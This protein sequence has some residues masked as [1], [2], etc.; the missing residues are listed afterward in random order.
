MS[1][2]SHGQAPKGNWKMKRLQQ[3]GWVSQNIDTIGMNWAPQPWL[4]TAEMEHSKVAWTFHIYSYR[5][6]KKHRK[7]RWRTGKGEMT[8]GI[9]QK[10]CQSQGLRADFSKHVT[11]PGPLSYRECQGLEDGVSVPVGTAG[12]TFGTVRAHLTHDLM[13]LGLSQFLL[14]ML[15][16]TEETGR[17]VKCWDGR[18]LNT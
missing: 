16:L 2:R 1:L 3:S 10:P 17:T 15:A 13:G 8:D 4:W 5:A 9:L 18:D 12:V 14:R 7:W 6:Y 11:W